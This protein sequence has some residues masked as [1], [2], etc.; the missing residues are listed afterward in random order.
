MCSTEEGQ[1][2][3]AEADPPTFRSYHSGGARA[4]VASVPL[5]T[6]LAEG[7]AH[8]SLTCRELCSIPPQLLGSATVERLVSLDL[9]R[10]RIDELPAGLACFLQLEVL[11]VSRNRLRSLPPELPPA[12]R[13]LLVLSNQL[14]R[15]SLSLLELAALPDLTLLDL[16]YNSKLGGV[17][18]ATVLNEA[19]PAPCVVRLT[20]SQR[21]VTSGANHGAPGRTQK[22]SAA[23]AD[24][25]QLR[26]QLD[27]IST[28]QLRGRLDRLFDQPTQPDDVDRAAVLSRLVEA[29]A[30][31]GGRAVRRMRG[32]L[33]RADAPV[34][35]LLAE[36]RATSFPSGAQRERPK[37]KAAG[38]MVLPRPLHGAAASEAVHAS[39]ADPR[40]VFDPRGAGAGSE[41]SGGGGDGAESTEGGGGGGAGAGDGGGGSGGGESS[42]GGTRHASEAS[43][44]AAAKLRRHARLW[45]L[46][47]EIV[48]GVD[49]QFA[50]RYTAVALTKQARMQPTAT[51][52]SSLQP[53]A[54]HCNT[55]SPL[56]RSHPLCPHS[57]RGR[58]TSTRRTSRP[59]TGY[60]S[61]TSRGAPSASRAGFSR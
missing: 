51:H 25:T 54:T 3:R 8:L 23:Q 57:S 21:Q 30:A 53:A 61:V 24:A 41:A 56:C 58:R 60:R 12:L 40:G 2:I 22:P 44:L 11:D 14:R 38:Y 18:T 15:R 39:E 27:P 28:P 45:D 37:V 36:L 20:S 46:A 48:R 55:Q 6:A 10:N 59:S 34:A 52:R 16:R 7:T 31:A 1:P 35:A 43:R 4:E 29:Y 49:P 26:S 5:A 47:H 13:S 19:L 32:V 50:E 33:P 42:E 17:D 9:S